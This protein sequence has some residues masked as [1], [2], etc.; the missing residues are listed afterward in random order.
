MLCTKFEVAIASTVA[1]DF[2][3]CS[4]SPHPRQFWFLKLFLVIL[5]KP[6]LYT[7]HEVDTFSGCRNKWGTHNFGGA[8]L[9]QRAPAKFSNKVVLA[10]YSPKPK[11]CTK[12]EV[13]SFNRCRTK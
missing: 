6:K 2:F 13:V 7:K 1:A 4:T 9:A 11:L 12:F 10:A 3:V 5:L 8:P